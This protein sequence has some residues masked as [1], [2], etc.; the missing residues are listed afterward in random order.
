[1]MEKP[2]T[3]NQIADHA[4]HI[5]LAT[6]TNLLQGKNIWRGMKS[7]RDAAAAP[8]SS[9]CSSHL[10]RYRSGCW[11]LNMWLFVLLVTLFQFGSAYEVDPEKLQGLARAKVEVGEA[12]FSSSSCFHVTSSQD[13]FL[14]IYF[15]TRLGSD[16]DFGE[17][18][19]KWMNALIIICACV[20]DNSKLK[21]WT[22][23]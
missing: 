18:G 8:P 19:W 21:G 23:M 4:P 17:S 15:L 11:V 10:S 6:P 12:F 7:G 5:L 9:S 1:M 3:A 16:L 20:N 13:G 14:F 2:H 22:L